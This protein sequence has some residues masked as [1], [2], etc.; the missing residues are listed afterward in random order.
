[1]IVLD[2]NWVYLRIKPM[3]TTVKGDTIEI[4][5]VNEWILF[6]RL[7][8][9]ISPIDFLRLTDSL[10]QLPN[11]LF[12]LSFL[13]VLFM[14]IDIQAKLF[15]PCFL[16]FIGQII[17][18]LKICISLTKFLKYPLLFFSSGNMTLMTIIFIT[19]VF[20]IKW[21]TFLVILLYWTTLI[22]SVFVLNY[23]QKKYYYEQWKFRTGL[24]DIFKN[25]AFLFSYKYFASLYDLNLDINPTENEIDNTVW[26]ESYGYMRNNWPKFR[27]GFSEKAQKYWCQYLRIEN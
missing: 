24:Y 19:S 7:S 22:V 4:N 23:N 25:N 21:W 16:Y 6:N 20:F 10:I 18:N 27:T 13:I 1:M 8:K 2:F 26:L 12:S 11:F 3:I 9:I 17:I 14:D 15:F 5:H